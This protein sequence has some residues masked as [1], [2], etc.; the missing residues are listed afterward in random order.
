M[1][2][3]FYVLFILFLLPSVQCSKEII[4][5]EAPAINLSYP[6]MF[7]A[8]CENLV[9]GNT[10]SIR[11]LLR[12]NVELDK[13]SIE[14]YHNF[15]GN[16][17]TPGSELCEPDTV[18]TPVYPFYYLNTFDI[19]PGKTEFITSSVIWFPEQDC[20]LTYFDEGVYILRVV[21]YDKKGLTDHK[22][23]NIKLNSPE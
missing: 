7:P 16:I 13:F 19:P 15:N 18:K 8:Y 9:L 23:I 2:R 21:V 3:F 17:I 14:I 22:L 1:N 4:D 6:D 5:E 20:C 11:F 10:Y 12:D